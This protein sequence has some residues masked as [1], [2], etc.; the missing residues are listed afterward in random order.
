MDML[1]Y[2]ITS[3]ELL[4]NEYD[5]NKDNQDNAD[6]KDDNSDGDDDYADDD[7]NETG[8]LSLLAWQLLINLAS[9]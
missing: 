9:S 5:D 6:H 1:Q 7:A 8:K 4:C 3:C 2:S